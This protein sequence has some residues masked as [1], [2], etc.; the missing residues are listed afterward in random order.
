MLILYFIFLGVG[1]LSLVAFNFVRVKEGGVK[2]LLLKAFTSSMFVMCAVF[3]CLN[4]MSVSTLTFSL[5]VI[6][7]LVFGLM[8]DI[9]LDLKFVYPNDNK[10]YTYAG[11]VS[12]LIGHFLFFEALIKNYAPT[13]TNP[14]YI[15]I[16]TLLAILLAAGIIILEKPMKMKYGEY[17]VVTF[18]Y[19][20][21]LVDVTLL[22]GALAIMNSFKELTL[23]VM[24]IG[25]VF[26]LISDLI[27]SGTYFGEGKDRPVDIIL[28]HTTYYIGQFL[29]ASSLLFLN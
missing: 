8:G 3:A 25:L 10:I 17:K 19:S 20:F 21:M 14:L 5:L 27:L 7:G 28:N 12:F 18:A 4:N 24:F 23:D 6:A 16:P 13:G 22:S 1:V 26:F 9:W 2:A 11:F 29:I 15:F